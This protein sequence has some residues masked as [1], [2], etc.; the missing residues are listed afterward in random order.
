MLYLVAR[1][2]K[3]A[4]VC[5]HAGHIAALREFWTDWLRD[6]CAAD[7]HAGRGIPAHAV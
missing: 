3:R 6:L 2:L 7:V 1:T 4:A 5:L